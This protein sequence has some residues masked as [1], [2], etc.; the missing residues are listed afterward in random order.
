MLG[1]AA[2]TNIRVPGVSEK[3]PGSMCVW[4]FLRRGEGEKRKKAGEGRS[5]RTIILSPDAH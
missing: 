4:G 2:S 1:V 3:L 5:W